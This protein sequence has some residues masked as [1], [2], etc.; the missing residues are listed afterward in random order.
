LVNIPKKLKIIQSGGIFGIE[1]RGK[2][3]QQSEVKAKKQPRWFLNFMNFSLGRIGEK[4]LLVLGIDIRER[5]YGEQSPL[6]I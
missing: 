1:Q 4:D 5:V 6:F 2:G 3:V